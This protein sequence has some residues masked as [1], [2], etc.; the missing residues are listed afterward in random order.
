MAWVL[1]GILSFLCLGA[2]AA[3][4]VSSN[5]A[6]NALLLV[7]AFACLG[8]L[9]GL[10]DAPF[11]AAV[12]VIIYAGAIMILFLFAIMM[13][14]LKAG[15]PPERRRYVLVLAGLLGAVL[16]AELLIVIRRAFLGAGGPGPADGQGPAG[17]G[18]LLFTRY[19]YPFEI[20]S[21]LLVAALVGAMAL[22]DKP[23]RKEAS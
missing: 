16:L 6:H 22:A 7:L 8:G 1:F 17:I 13:V 4:I 2:V 11:A 3:M 18:H 23:G 20:T 12:Q 21:L 14:D 9:F 10:L 15:L 5:Q 19:L